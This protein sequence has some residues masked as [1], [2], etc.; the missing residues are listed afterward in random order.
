MWWNHCPSCALVDTYVTFHR[1]SIC[2]VKKISQCR[3]VFLWKRGQL[4]WPT[5]YGITGTSCTFRGNCLWIPAGKFNTAVLTFLLPGY[6]TA[7][8]KTAFPIYL[9]IFVTWTALQVVKSNID[10]VSCFLF[11]V[12][13]TSLHSKAFTCQAQR[14]DFVIVLVNSRQC[15]T[16]APHVSNTGSPWLASEV[17]SDDIVWCSRVPKELAS[18]KHPTQN[19]AGSFC[20]RVLI[21]SY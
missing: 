11:E 15:R 10:T 19:F 12:N 1:L 8:I 21:D 20:P 4:E 14:I 6:Q 17:D 7:L 18:N 5:L 2:D 13:V 16:C 9:Y 3:V